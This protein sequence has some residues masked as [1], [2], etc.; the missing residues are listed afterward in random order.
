MGCF[1]SAPVGGLTLNPIA[2]SADPAASERPVPAWISVRPYQT[3]ILIAAFAML[4]VR[5]IGRHFDIVDSGDVLPK[6]G[7]DVFWMPLLTSVILLI[8][9]LVFWAIPHANSR[10]WASFLN[11][12]NTQIG[13][14]L[15]TGYFGWVLL[16]LWTNGLAKRDAKAESIDRK[17]TTAEAQINQRKLDE[18]NANFDRHQANLTA[19]VGSWSAERKLAF[20]LQDQRER[21]A[22]QRL[23]LEPADSSENLLQKIQAMKQRIEDKI[24]AIEPSRGTVLTRQSLEPLRWL[25]KASR[26]NYQPIVMKLAQMKRID[27]SVAVDISMILP[28][29]K[30]FVSGRAIDL[31]Q[32]FR[33]KSCLRDGLLGRGLHAQGAFYGRTDGGDP[34]GSGS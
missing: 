16:E 34:A 5:A 8:D 1:V 29:W 33:T 17:K 19:E 20:S 10:A 18:Q 28:A 31:P 24:N 2:L 4:F 6:M 25:S 32:D 26:S 12:A 21:E 23:Q 3:V 27:S 14:V 22:I 11:F 13:A 30:H 15:L 9:A 7:R